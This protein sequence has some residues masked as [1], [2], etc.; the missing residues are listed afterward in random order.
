MPEVSVLG[1]KQLQKEQPSGLEADRFVKPAEHTLQ[2]L[3]STFDLHSH[4]P[5][6]MSQVLLLPSVPA[7]L[8]PHGMQLAD[9]L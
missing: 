1:M 6:T 9:M 4:W 2:V 7:V 3:P 8:Q 5:M